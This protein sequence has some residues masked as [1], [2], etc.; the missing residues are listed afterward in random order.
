MAL[1]HTAREE[2]PESRPPFSAILFAKKGIV[3]I[4]GFDRFFCGSVLKVAFDGTRTGVADVGRP[5]WTFV[6]A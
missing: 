1:C 4:A 3:P 2:P 5:G 6:L